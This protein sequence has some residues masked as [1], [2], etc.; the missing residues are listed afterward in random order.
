[1]AG[2]APH[3]GRA[4]S[5]R[6][7][8]SACWSA[9]TRA[10]PAGADPTSLAQPA[11]PRGCGRWAG[12]SGSS[13][14]RRCEE[15]LSDAEIRGLP[16]SWRCSPRCARTRQT[17][18][19]HH[20]VV[21]TVNDLIAIPASPW[22]SATSRSTFRISSRRPRIACAR[23]STI[24]KGRAKRRP[25]VSRRSRVATAGSAAC[26][27]NRGAAEKG[28]DVAASGN[29]A[30]VDEPIVFHSMA[31]VLSAATMDEELVGASFR[32]LNPR[33]PSARCAGA[34]RQR[35]GS[36]RGPAHGTDCAGPQGPRRSVRYEGLRGV[37]SME[38][39]KRRLRP[40]RR[41][42]LRRSRRHRPG[43]NRR[44]RRVVPEDEAIDG[45]AGERGPDAAERSAAGTGKRTRSWRWRNAS[46]IAPPAGCRR[47]RAT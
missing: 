36:G 39:A 15:F 32:E 43:R 12:S 5:Y 19:P 13:W 9:C 40:D 41:R 22:C 8:T 34:L 1:M 27:T 7:R 44:A 31:A 20:L 21:E 18:S 45:T 25:V 28:G 33:A 4:R 3:R 14:C 16:R 24:R 35:L 47:S 6:R 10:D 26:A 29:A 38:R 42:A 46:L 2:D 37:G 30:P 23:S 17:S 11:P